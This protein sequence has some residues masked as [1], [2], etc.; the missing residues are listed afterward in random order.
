MSHQAK[1]EQYYPQ[2]S[3]LPNYKKG[4]TWSSEKT[5]LDILFPLS[6]ARHVK[7]SFPCSNPLFDPHASV[8]TTLPSALYGHQLGMNEGSGIIYYTHPH[9]TLTHDYEDNTGK[10]PWD[11]IILTVPLELLR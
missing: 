3:C 9:Y 6:P 11:L 4:D 10:T 1:V 8:K 2:N 5:E 7:C